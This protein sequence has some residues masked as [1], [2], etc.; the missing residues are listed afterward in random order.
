MAGQL[1]PAVKPTLAHSGSH[2]NLQFMAY[3]VNGSGH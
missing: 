1:A 2:F 3:L